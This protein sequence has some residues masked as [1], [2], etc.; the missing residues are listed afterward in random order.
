MDDKVFKGLNSTEV[1]ESRKVNGTNA[2]TQIEQDP[3]WKK[4][5]EGF[6]DP[7]L[8]ILIAALVIQLIFVFMGRGE[9]FEAV[10]IFV[11]IIVANL[12][13]VLSENKQEGKAAE[14]RAEAQAKERT[15]VIRDGVLLEIPV[16]DVVVGDIVV[17]QAGDKVPADGIVVKGEIKVD[18]ATLNGE[19]KEAKKTTLG[20]NELGNIKDLLN[21]Y[22]VYRGTVVCEGECYFE[23]KVV[24]DKTIYGELALEMQ[25]DTRETPLKVKLGKLADQIS[26][27]GYI[28]AVCIAISF[29]VMHILNHGMPTELIGWFEMLIEAVSLA[30]V[31]VVMA[32]PEGNVAP[33]IQ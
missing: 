18:Q 21:E 10:G 13:G 23:A 17:L 6:K 25:E 33:V 12:V 4:L 16:N 8:M 24:G 19:T 11:A 32:V 29:I 15:K 5:L 9:W 22:Y 14:L 30:V 31:I 7:M 20:D 3:L 26:K 2:L 1:E 27:F 28:G